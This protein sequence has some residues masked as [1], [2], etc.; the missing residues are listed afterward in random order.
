M[1]FK[2]LKLFTLFVFG[3]G[4]YG[5]Q[6]QNS[7]ITTGGNASGSGGSVS[8]TV[9]QVVYSS[10][11]GTNGSVSEGVQQPYEISIISGFEEV[12]GITLNCTAYPNPTSDFLILRI[13]NDLLKHISY[14][15]FDVNGKLL[16]TKKIKGIQTSIVTS[17]L[18][19]AI[20]FLKVIQSD[21]EIKTFKIIKK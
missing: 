3:Y 19:P 4:L 10:T 16:D 15:L 9:G 12:S 1:K 5:L 17:Y 14:Q 21:K 6:A 11:V 7:V 2:K 8:Y 20:Y 13:E 18:V